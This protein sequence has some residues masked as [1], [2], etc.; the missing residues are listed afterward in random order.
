MK[1]WIALLA[2]FLASPVLAGEAHPFLQGSWQQLREQHR[3]KPTIVHFWGITCAPCMVEMPRWAKLAEADRGLNLV[4]IDADPVG[5]EGNGP[6][7][8]RMGLSQTES[9]RFADDFTERLRFEVDPKWHGELPMTLLI[10]RD[11]SVRKIL[12]SADFSEV[13]HWLDEQKH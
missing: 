11:G 6:M 12:G 10:G 1:G 5:E 2:A 4:L 8:A 9:W 13:R 3:G 7:L